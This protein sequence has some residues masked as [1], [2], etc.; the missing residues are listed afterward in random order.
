MARE[1][2]NTSIDYLPSIPAEWDIGKVK[3]AFFRKDEK[4]E[5][6]DP[7]VL[8]L[9]RSG[10]KVRD[11]SNN[12]GQIA[13]SYY[14]YNPVMPQDLL[15]NPMDLISGAN[16]SLSE[17]EGVISPAYINLRA[18]D[19]I[20]PRYF[21]FYFKLQ[22]WSMSF[23]AHGKG[24]SYDNRWTM[25]ANTILNY[26][27]PMPPYEEQ[28]CIADFL[29]DKCAK[30]DIAI[31]KTQKTIEE[32]KALKRSIITEA[33]TKGIRDDRPLKDSGIEWIGDIP[34]CWTMKKIKHL[35]AIF[36]G[37]TPK[38]A[39]NDYWDG[40]INWITPADYKTQD[41]Y[42]SKG[43]RNISQVGYDSCGTTL[44]PT[45]SIVFSK[46]APVGTVA[47]TNAEI[48]TNQGCLSCVPKEGTDSTYYYY[49]MSVFTEQ[50]E[51][52]SAGTTFK[53]IAADVFANFYLPHPSIEEQLEIAN[54]LDEL[55]SSIDALV[56]NK[57]KIIEELELYKKSLIYEYVTGKKEVM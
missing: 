6:N 36:S 19:N 20:H 3:N 40:N 45:G 34:M 9:A 33:V 42:V 30:I 31:E 57:E 25:N 14:N 54:H 24:V 55:C 28:K 46:R 1:M 16:C 8:S 39:N 22:Y 7:I 4:A 48:C 5:Q 12:D 41:K 50:F 15:L 2:K 52:V 17:V 56:S 21:D 53:E 29:D 44:V 43:K 51:L 47:I 23:F 11:L 10:V 35:F 13:E 37:A 38:S 27:I 32:Y 49:A 18:R 26:H